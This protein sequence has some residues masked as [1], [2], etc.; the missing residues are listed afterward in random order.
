MKLSIEDFKIAIGNIQPKIQSYFVT[1]PE[2][3]KYFS[4]TPEIT[5][6]NLIIGISFTYSWMPTVLKCIDS[7]SLENAVKLMNKVR[8]KEDITKVELETIMKCTNNSLVGASKLLHFIAPDRYAIWD[9]KVCQ[10]YSNAKPSANLNK[11]I[12]TYFDYLREC[13]EL[14]AEPEYE[15]IHLQVCKTLEEKAGV[16]YEMSK[17]RTVE[18]IMYYSGFKDK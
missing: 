10:Y 5:N 16:K 12:D 11:Q 13:R 6:H 1:Y 2:F 4:H 14:T 9:S 8:S 7:G 18:L 17:M 3:L 15:A